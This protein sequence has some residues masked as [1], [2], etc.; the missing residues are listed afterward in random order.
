MTSENPKLHE[1]LELLVREVRDESVEACDVPRSARA[2]S[3]IAKRWRTVRAN[4]QV[5][6]AVLPDAVDLTIFEFLDAIDTGR[7]R[8]AFIAADNTVVDL[9]EEGVGELGGWYI[10]EGGYRDTYA[11]QRRGRL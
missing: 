9:F 11:K 3:G 8:L 4:D 2:K 10:M 6:D 5:L 1:F 7:L